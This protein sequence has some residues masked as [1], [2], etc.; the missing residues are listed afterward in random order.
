MQ[1]LFTSFLRDHCAILI[2]LSMLLAGGGGWM[3][4]S[5]ASVDTTINEPGDGFTSRLALQFPDGR[6]EIPPNQQFPVLRVA[7]GTLCELVSID[8]DGQ[9]T[10]GHEFSRGQLL[11][12]GKRVHLRQPLRAPLEPMNLRYQQL[13]SDGP[14]TNLM[15]AFEPIERIATASAD[16][17]GLRMFQGR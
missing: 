6:I 13:A 15:I 11:L 4:W 5:A 14:N 10:D 17:T 8:A 16:Q 7:P 2:T 3:S 12:N 9:I 1:S